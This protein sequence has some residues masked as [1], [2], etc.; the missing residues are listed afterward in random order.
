[1]VHIYIIYAAHNIQGRFIPFII[2]I[3][4]ITKQGK[5]GKLEPEVGYIMNVSRSDNVT[6][7]SAHFP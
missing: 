5:E 2:I 6:R 7:M 4:V 1:M 3:I